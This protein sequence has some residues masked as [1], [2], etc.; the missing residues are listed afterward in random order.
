MTHD[1]MPGPP[2][3]PG[4]TCA[5]YAPLLP[6]LPTGE[7]TPKQESTTREH[8]GSCAWC[9]SRLAEYDTLY[10]ALRSRFDPD[11]MAAGVPIPSAREIAA[12]GAGS[13]AGER[14]RPAS[15][16]AARVEELEQGAAFARG[17]VPRWRVPRVPLRFEVAA[18]V[19]L[20]ALLGGLLLWQHGA[21]QAGPPPLDA[22]SQAYVAVLRAN[23]LPLL[24]AAGTEGRQCVT[25]FDKKPAGDRQQAMADCR[26][27]E[28]TALTAS[29]TLLAQLQAASAPTRWQSADAQLKVWAQ[30]QIDYYAAR[31]QAID[32]HDLAAFK[33]LGDV[34]MGGGTGSSVSICQAIQQINAD[35]PTD[36]QLPE[37]ALGGCA[38]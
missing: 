13:V 23:Y 38:P 16:R 18:A 37:S 31:I 10:A 21:G 30:V 14:G 7:L 9:R 4:P 27:L 3:G 29:Q 36:S 28:V 1:T 12:L 33:Q 32:A 6:L 35:L 17:D 22:Q 2:Q 26:P 5:V 25:A 34:G 20:I 24:D 19:L 8:L 15:R 11:V